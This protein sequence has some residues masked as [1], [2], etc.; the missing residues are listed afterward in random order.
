M[1]CILCQA[2]AHTP[3]AA[4]YNTPVTNTDAQKLVT[5]GFALNIDSKDQS[6]ELCQLHIQLVESFRK[7][8][9]SQ[10]EAE[11]AANIPPPVAETAVRERM[12]HLS[13]NVGPT[14]PPS[15]GGRVGARPM[16]PPPISPEQS[17]NDI[18]GSPAI[19]ENVQ[20]FSCPKCGKK[21]APGEVHPCL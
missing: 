20:T 2:W 5:Y 1:T 15:Q 6:P 19:V 11:A 21:V 3:F 14:R 4:R 18:V 13:R 16:I 10:R 17:T 12:S 8:V 7:S 9:N